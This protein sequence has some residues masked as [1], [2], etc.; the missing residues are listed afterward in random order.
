[1]F[2]SLLIGD[3][4]KAIRSGVGN[5]EG[6]REC[7]VGTNVTRVSAERQRNVVAGAL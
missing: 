5:R 3:G 4:E 7:G 2:S 1:M 6:E